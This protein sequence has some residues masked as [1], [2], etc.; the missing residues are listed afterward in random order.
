MN[1]VASFTGEKKAIAKYDEK[2]QVAYAAAVQQGMA[3]GLGLGTLLLIVFCTYGL[4]TWYGSKLIIEKG[5][6]G[7]KVINVIIA[8]MTGGM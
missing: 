7:G 4:A 3:S 2:L 5:Y 1:K 6:S 8:M